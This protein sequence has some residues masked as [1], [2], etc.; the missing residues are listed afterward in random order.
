MTPEAK[1][2]QNEPKSNSPNTVNEKTTDSRIPHSQKKLTIN[3]PMI[4]ISW[5]FL[6]MVLILL[7]A[8]RF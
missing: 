6:L 8:I 5:I 7:G 2:Q 1:L 3:R 4:K